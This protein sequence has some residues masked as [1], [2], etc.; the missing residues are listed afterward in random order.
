MGDGWDSTHT[1]FYVDGRDETRAPEL[2]G[3]GWRRFRS[4]ALTA[5]VASALAAWWLHAGPVGALLLL[6]PFGTIV[7]PVSFPALYIPER[8]TIA[9]IRKRRARSGVERLAH[10]PA[11]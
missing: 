2:R 3:L 10:Q 11:E 8:L 5:L 1:R 6:I 4:V 7:F 9:R